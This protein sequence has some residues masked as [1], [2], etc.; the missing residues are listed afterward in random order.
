[1]K[2]DFN[3]NLRDLSDKEMEK[4]NA[5]RILA[6]YLS[7]SPGGDP[8]KNWEWARKLHAGQV[9]DLDSSDCD[10]LQNFIEKHENLFALSKAQLL[11]V[12]SEAKD[13]EKKAKESK[14]K[15]K[16]K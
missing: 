9:L 13:S 15:T 7:V 12:I 10:K 4:E 6:Q 16:V 1:M 14:N 5:G 11:Y 3:F 2:I 8:L